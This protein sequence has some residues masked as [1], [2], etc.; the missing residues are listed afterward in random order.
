MQFDGGENS[1][2]DSHKGVLGSKWCYLRQSFD[3]IIAKLNLRSHKG[4]QGGQSMASGPD[5]VDRWNKSSQQG[6]LQL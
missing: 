2:S 4:T 3:L 1:Q 5:S 6:M